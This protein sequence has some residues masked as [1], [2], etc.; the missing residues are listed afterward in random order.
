MTSTYST[1]V[2]SGSGSG[3]GVYATSESGFALEA[4]SNG[5]PAVYANN[6]NGNAGDMTGTYIGVV[7]RA[8]AGGFPFVATDP[9]GATNLFYVTGSGDIYYHGGL[10]SFAAMTS[11]TQA[12]A[13]SPQ[14]TRPAI[15]DTGTARLTDGRAS[16]A[17]DPGLDAKPELAYIC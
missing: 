14:S 8:P 11:G 2:Y 6:V 1:G 13:Y 17:L 10:H 5:E 7:A 3:T 4:H 12:Q 15:E 16:V 9:S